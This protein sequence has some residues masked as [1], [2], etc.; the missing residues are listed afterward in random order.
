ML[1]PSPN[2]RRST[3]WKTPPLLALDGV[4]DMETK[5]DDLPYGL[6]ADLHGGA[7]NG[8]KVLLFLRSGLQL[9]AVTAA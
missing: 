8:Y 2:S 5:L 4:K 3:L 1:L 7:S 9:V 6:G